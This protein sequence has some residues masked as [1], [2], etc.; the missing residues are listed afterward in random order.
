MWVIK[1]LGLIKLLKLGVNC[2]SGSHGMML[3]TNCGIVF[4]EREIENLSVNLFS[5][6]FF[7]LYIFMQERGIFIYFSLQ[8]LFFL[9]MKVKKKKKNYTIFP[10]SYVLFDG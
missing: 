8:L 1:L 10:L 6:G 7:D 3:R 5:S 4:T 2:H 9:K